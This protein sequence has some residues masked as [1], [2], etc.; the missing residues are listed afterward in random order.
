MPHDCTKCIHCQV[1]TGAKLHAIETGALGK[2]SKS[3]SVW[4]CAEYDLG[5]HT[6]LSGCVDT[7]LSTYGPGSGTDRPSGVLYHVSCHTKA[8]NALRAVKTAMAGA[9]ATSGTR[10]MCWVA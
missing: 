1:E 10:V 5:L 4:A 3:A 2:L 9:K 7:D 6:R 8:R